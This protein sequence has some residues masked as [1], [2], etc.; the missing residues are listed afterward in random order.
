MLNP[1]EVINYYKELKERV[2]KI[3]DPVEK[4]T[5]VEKGLNKYTLNEWCEVGDILRNA[6]LI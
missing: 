5:A 3:T 1:Q 4:T 6:N 2:S